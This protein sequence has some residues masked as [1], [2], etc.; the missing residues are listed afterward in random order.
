[1][2]DLDVHRE[3]INEPFGAGRLASRLLFDAGVMFSCLKD[4][5]G[6]NRV[7]DF[8][9]GTCWVSEWLMRMGYDVTTLDMDE[10]SAR[11]GR[12]R[13]EC[14]KRVNPNSVHFTCGDGHDM[15]FRDSI[16][17]HICCFDSLHHMQSYP[18]VLSEFHRVLIP[19]GRAIFV[20]P[21]SKHSTSKETIDFMKRFKKDDPTWIERDVVLEDI[22]RISQECGFS[23]MTIRPSLHPHLR[24]YD[25]RT[26]Q[27]FRQ[28]DRM[29]GEDY[30]SWLS[31]FNYE[32]R[33][34]YYLDKAAIRD[35]VNFIAAVKTCWKGRG[36]G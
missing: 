4:D 25:F 26:W 36:V 19:G 32:D 6:N 12:V 20:E 5:A 28:G 16:F 29:L 8:G 13:V 10:G 27:R 35:N 15:P 17:S 21:G 14:D 7:L 22:S 18:R 33:V 11:V 30:L 1:M 3:A 2:N 24:E 31:A 34:V 23:K 9:A